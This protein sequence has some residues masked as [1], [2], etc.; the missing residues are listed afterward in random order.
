MS[1]HIRLSHVVFTSLIC[2]FFSYLWAIT[3]EYTSLVMILAA[4]LFL[5]ISCALLFVVVETSHYNSVTNYVEA[6]VK[7]DSDLRNQLAFS[8]PSFR[9][10]AKRGRVQTLFAE[11]RATKEHIHLFLQDSTQ[12][13]TASKRNWH[14]SERPAWAWEEIYT[15]LLDHKMVGSFA[16]GPDSYP[17]VGTAYQNL[18]VYFLSQSIQ[19]LEPESMVYASETKAETI[20]QN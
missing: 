6:L 20:H 12:A 1:Y 4:G 3:K 13:Q 9:L 7:M 11:T 2:V 19:N 15:Y 10:I 8:V 16:T 5:V 17:W 18:C 14:T